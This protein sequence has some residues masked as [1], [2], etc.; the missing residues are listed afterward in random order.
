MARALAKRQHRNLPLNAL[1]AFEAAARHSS[2]QQ[3]ADELCVTPAAVS[4]Q[5]KRLEEVLGT[6]LFL[7]EHRA[8]KLTVAG[9]A[10]ADD[11][12]AIFA[13]L[14]LAIDRVDQRPTAV[15]RVSTVESLAAKWLTPRLVTFHRRYPTIRLRLETRDERVDLSR[16]D[17]DVAIRYGT[18]RYAGAVEVDHLMDAPAFPVCSPEMLGKR[19]SLSIKD[20]KRMTLLHDE[21]AFGRAN[22][23]DWAAWLDANGVDGVDV[24]RGPTFASLYLAQEAAVAGHGIALGLAPLVQSD[25][26]AGRLVRPFQGALPN[27]YAF[28]L[29]RKRA[30]RRPAVSAFCKWLKEQA[31]TL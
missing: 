9:H 31:E 20:L 5:V 28:W 3:A 8:V 25:I 12:R 14:H 27:A 21:T 13:Q 24:S 11:L 17:I 1:K 23:P 16:G 18:G 2:L 7:R 30:E 4:H 15:V 26:Q 22:V 6:A 19:N 29:I 10:L